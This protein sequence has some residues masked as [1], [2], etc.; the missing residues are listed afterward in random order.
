[1]L[2]SNLRSTLRRTLAAER[3]RLAGRVARI[4]TDMRHPDA[5]L[6]ADADDQA[7]QL[8]NDPVL[9]ALDEQGRRQLAEIDAALHRLDAGSYGVCA[10]CEEA[11]PRERMVAL[12]TATTCARCAG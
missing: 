12:P 6:E 10:R 3:R 1:V 2:D 11:I 8:E 5:P 9:D 7:I 4:A